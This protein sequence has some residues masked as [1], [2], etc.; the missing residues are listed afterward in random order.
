M[1]ECAKRGLRKG[2]VYLMYQRRRRRRPRLRGRL[3]RRPRQ[4]GYVRNLRFWASKMKFHFR[5]PKD[6]KRFRE[7][8]RYYF[9]GAPYP[10]RSPSRARG[11]AHTGFAPR[12]EHELRLRVPRC[13]LPCSRASAGLSRRS[14]GQDP[15]PSRASSGHVAQ[16][17]RARERSTAR[18][19]G[20]TA[21][22]RS[23]ST[24][25]TWRPPGPQH[26]AHVHR[27]GPRGD[28]RVPST[29]CR[30]ERGDTIGLFREMGE[31]GEATA[32]R[33]AAL[34]GRGPRGPLVVAHGGAAGLDAVVKLMEDHRKSGGRSRCL[35]PIGVLKDYHY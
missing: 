1:L 29:L 34:P 32:S 14:F 26:Y 2:A 23:A 33:D 10:P 5:R 24:R 18:T 27:S 19:S 25:A 3:L 16:H 35:R 31:G 7:K 9:S 21:T 6:W 11:P 17:D 4:E 12:G 15:A 13:L 8:W 30:T 28:R 22:T 20:S